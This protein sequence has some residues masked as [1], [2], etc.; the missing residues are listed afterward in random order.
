MRQGHRPFAA[1][2]RRRPVLEV[3]L[4]ERRLVPSAVPRP[5][6][7]VI[8]I[9]ENHSYSEIIGS[10]AAP[11][12]NSLAQQGA[13]I[14]NSLAVMHPSE[15]NYLDL[16]SGSNQ[17]VTDDSVPHSFSAPNLASELLSAGFSFGGYSESLPYPGF[18]GGSF[19]NAYFAKHN[20]WVAFTNV[21]AADN[22]P[23]T[24]YF[25]SNYAQLPT[26]SIVVPNIY[27][28]MHSGPIQ[29]GDAW[30]RVNLD[31]YVQWARSN[32][33]LL[34]VT[35][36]EDDSSAGNHIPTLFV[37]P[38]VTP[39]PYG[40]TINHIDLLRTLED[41]YGLPYAGA[42]PNATPVTYIWQAANEKFV[43]ALYNDFLGRSGGLPELDSWAA[44]L[45]YIGRAGVAQ[46]IK[47][48]PEAYTRV[49]D[50]FYLQFLGRP[51]DAG[52]EQGWVGFLE[53]GGTEEQLA[54]GFLSSPEYA[55]RANELFGSADPR[56]NFIQS[57]YSLLLNRTAGSDE[58][59]HWLPILSQVGTVAVVRGF[60]F[61]TEFRNAAV[62]SL[63]GDPS[64][65]PLPWE[66]FLPN[67]L[68][69]F[70]PPRQDEISGWVNTGQD[71]HLLEV[72]FAGS[73]EYFASAQIR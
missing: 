2:L 29:Q 23:F 71:L 14:T 56:A 6:H 37:G 12:I 18:T 68:H 41:M 19:A 46:G 15:P 22:M 7:V 32:N 28:D 51:A 16:F 45:P 58:V 57:L 30:L 27:D 73:E 67:L 13:L 70:V 4:L 35:W 50:S 25:P 11:Y 31:G 72:G 65:Q 59:N 61:S 52:G 9:E 5:D 38:M 44:A 63:Y 48:S 24:S 60:V 42:T 17:G 64:L 49:V 40:L 54:A 21:P 3:E 34:I 36:D 53:Q 33:S 26:V 10:P 39:G 62:R 1:A 66:P 69:R 8:V 55:N 20:P 43:Q 47:H